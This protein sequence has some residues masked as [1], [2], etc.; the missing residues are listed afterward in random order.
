MDTVLGLFGVAVWV[1]FTIGLAAGVT[2]VVVRFL[3]GGEKP[4]KPAADAAKTS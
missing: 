3:P 4:D 1:V 2:Y